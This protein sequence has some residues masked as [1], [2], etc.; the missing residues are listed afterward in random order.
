M[1]VVC[2]GWDAANR[3]ALH[4]ALLVRLFLTLALR[5]GGQVHGSCTK[6]QLAHYY[7][8]DQKQADQNKIGKYVVVFVVVFLHM[9]VCFVEGQ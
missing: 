8:Y 3:L 5:S 9:V 1:G 7:D 4:F 2:L 6:N